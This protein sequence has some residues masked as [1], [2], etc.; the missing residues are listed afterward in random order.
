[1]IVRFSNF[2]SRIL[3]IFKAILTLTM[4][5][6]SRHSSCTDARKVFPRICRP[7]ECLEEA[8][9]DLWLINS[10]LKIKDHTKWSLINALRLWC[11]DQRSNLD[12]LKIRNTRTNRSTRSTANDIE[13]LPFGPFSALKSLVL[14]LKLHFTTSQS[15]GSFVIWEIMWKFID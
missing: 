3:S 11:K 5:N 1:M 14:T 2:F 12:S 7:T 4:K 15:A 8:I 9:F 13:L 10:S 6:T